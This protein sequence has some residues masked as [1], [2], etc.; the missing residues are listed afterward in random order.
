M[1]VGAWKYTLHI[2]VIE[3]GLFDT[4]VCTGR[5]VCWPYS[6][7]DFRGGNASP[8][9]ACIPMTAMAKCHLL[10]LETTEIYLCSVV[11]PRSPMLG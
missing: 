4:Q 3:G 10:L 1:H 2:K 6:R 8:W 7:E 11:G 9:R 5:G